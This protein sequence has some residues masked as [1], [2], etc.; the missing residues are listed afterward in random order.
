MK[1]TCTKCKEE[2]PLSNFYKDK[3]RKDGYYVR[4]RVCQ[5]AYSREYRKRFPDKSTNA[6]I[7]YKY[8]ITLEEYRAKLESQYDCCAIC[9]TLF[10]GGKKKSFFIDHNHRTGQVRGLL[11]RECNLMIGHAKDSADILRSAIFYLEETWGKKL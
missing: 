2:Q 11:C 4:C 6:T 9:S 8:G 10:P 3:T 7:K 1:K 5:A